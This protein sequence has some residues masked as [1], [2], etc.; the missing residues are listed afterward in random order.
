MTYCLAWKDKKNVYM[1]ADSAVS[2]SVLDT[3]LESS[4]FGD[5]HEKRGKNYVYE[6]TLKLQTINNS[7]IICYAGNLITINGM[8]ELLSTQLECGINVSEA[9]ETIKN[10]LSNFDADFLIGYIESNIPVLLHFDGENL[11]DKEYCQIGSGTS[12][13]SWSYRNEF[14]RNKN[15]EKGASPNQ[16]LASTVVILQIYSLKEN[17]MNL[18]VGGLIFGL[19]LD[20]E[21]IHWCKDTTYYL[22]NIDL[23]DYHLVTVIARDNNLHVLSSLNSMHLIFPSHQNDIPNKI[24]HEQYSEFLHKSMTDYFVF[25]S[26]FYPTIVLIQIS[27]RI[28][29]EYFRLYYK[30]DGIY[31]HYRFIINPEIAN[32]INGVGYPEDE[33]VF[34]RW[35]LALS[36]PYKS[37]KDVIIE[38]GHQDLVEDYDDE[39]FI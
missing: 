24:L 15:L 20:N 11:I 31:T 35:E 34:F 7:Y 39:G 10:S 29:N 38:N 12:S 37:R 9:F 21:G 32:L 4:S 16:S 17:M 6:G 33:I 27:G 18:G 26:V 25:A 13:E 19:R 3:E 30:R 1:V 23:M 22:Y 5:I 14:I 2:S 36:I 8:L 28:H